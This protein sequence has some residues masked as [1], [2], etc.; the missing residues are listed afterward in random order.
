VSTVIGFDG[1]CTCYFKSNFITRDEN[2]VSK[3]VQMHNTRRILYGSSSAECCE[4]F[5]AVDHKNNNSLFETANH[6]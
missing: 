1:L 3:H 4:E 5:N 2:G 6:L